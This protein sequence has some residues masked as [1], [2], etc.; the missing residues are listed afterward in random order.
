MRVLLV[1]SSTSSSLGARPEHL[2]VEVKGLPFI[3]L[4]LLCLIITVSN[5]LIVSPVYASELPYWIGEWPSTKSKLKQA[6]RVLGKFIDFLASSKSKV[7]PTSKVADSQTIVFLRGIADRTV[8]TDIAL[9]AQFKEQIYPSMQKRER[10]LWQSLAKNCIKKIGKNSDGQQAFFVDYFKPEKDKSV[11]RSFASQKAIL[12]KQKEAHRLFDRLLAYTDSMPIA[13]KKVL[14]R[15][16]IE[17]DIAPI[18]KST[19]DVTVLTDLA[20]CT[21][22]RQSV[23]EQ[24][25]GAGD[26][27]FDHQFWSC[28]R[29]IA[30]SSDRKATEALDSIASLIHAQGMVALFLT[31]FRALQL[32]FTSRERY[33]EYLDGKN[34]PCPHK[35]RVTPIEQLWKE[36]LEGKL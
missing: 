33:F 4:L 10:V 32:G 8:L 9:S 2:K 26:R 6:Q 28:V 3:V 13:E 22:Y 34:V 7:V 20:V 16:K 15:T 21:H 30:I 12:A 27:V 24:C 23:Y 1:M 36:H 35:S 19:S 25:F 29:E 31:E 5:Q 14:N 17:H 18:L 11:R